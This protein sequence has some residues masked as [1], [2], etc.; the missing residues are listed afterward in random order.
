[1][2]SQVV[3]VPP[4]TT[5]TRGSSSSTL[6]TTTHFHIPSSQHGP[7]SSSSSRWQSRQ[8]E[9]LSDQ[10]TS[11]VLA[12]VKEGS[13]IHWEY[14]EHTVT[15][16]RTGYQHPLRLQRVVTA[17]VRPVTRKEH[18]A[19]VVRWTGRT[20]GVDGI[21][22]ATREEDLLSYND[23]FL[24]VLRILQDRTAKN[25]QEFLQ[26]FHQEEDEWLERMKEGI[27][28]RRNVSPY[29]RMPATK[30]DHRQHANSAV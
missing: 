25:K 16:P 20:V 15:D 13:A 11:Y 19:N 24:R 29:G 2:Q 17:Y 1:M 6:P 26:Q 3:A 18:D 8:H 21:V 10:W 30:L 4:V 9:Q 14:I 22:S 5:T 7:S 12:P 27:R 28:P 23:E